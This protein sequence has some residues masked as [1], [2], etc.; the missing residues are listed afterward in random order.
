MYTLF[1]TFE[2]HDATIDLAAIF[3]TKNMLLE[4]IFLSRWSGCSSIVGSEKTRKKMQFSHTKQIRQNNIRCNRIFRSDTLYAL[5]DFKNNRI[6]A[7][8][9]AG[10]IYGT[11]GPCGLLFKAAGKT[12]NQV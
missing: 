6:I 4:D 7:C 11:F 8:L 12:E 1:S 9:K 2:Y 10:V 3:G 5:H